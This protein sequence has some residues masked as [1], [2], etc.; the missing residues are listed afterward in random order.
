[1]VDRAVRKALRETV[2]R[3][4]LVLRIN[5]VAQETIDR[6]VLI[7]AAFAGQLALLVSDDR[8]ERRSDPT[9]LRRMAECRELSA[10]R[11]TELLAAQEA[12]ST[13][14]AR[15]LDGHAALFPDAVV[16]WA[17]RL[18][19]AQELAVMADRLAEL[20]G[21]PPAAPWDPDAVATRAALLVAD[22]V[23]PARSTALDKL[24]EGRQTLAIATGWLRSK[25]IADPAVSRS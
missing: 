7:Y 13:A 18:R 10:G 19:L 23:E 16:A 5:L 15:Y 22:L 8:T 9:Y 20:D 12:R 21:V 4:E 17:E 2:F 1:M 25:R 14:E 6:E 11:V 3:F 24:D